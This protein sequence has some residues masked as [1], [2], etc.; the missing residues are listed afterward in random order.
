MYGSHPTI[1]VTGG[2]GY[3]GSHIAQL[4]ASL[5]YHVIIIDDLSQQGNIAALTAMHHI[6]FFQADFADTKLLDLLFTTYTITA[7][8]HCA[9]FIEVGESVRNPLRYYN[10]NVAKTITLLEHM[11]KHG[12]NNFIFS[13]S[14]AVYGVP[15]QLPLKEEHPR[16]PISPYGHTK[17]MVEQILAAMAT[18]YDFKYVAL[19]YF[20]AAGA[21]TEYNLGE[22]HTPETHL[23]P[24]VIEAALHDK[25]FTLFG[26]HHPTPDGTCV[27]DFVHVRDI[28]HAHANALFYLQAGGKSDLFNL[29]TGVGFSVTQIINA[30]EKITDKKINVVSAPARAGDPPI[31]IACS[32]KALQSLAWQAHYS[33]LEYII[34]TAVEFKLLKKASVTGHINLNVIKERN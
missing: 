27:R 5:N 19:R 22:L 23:I 8:I 1:I 32:H 9:A 13:S 28:A 14:C 24:L 29:G 16:S 21:N 7:V 20:N 17:L 18:A 26:T 30:V 6:T 15:Q 33:V 34:Q 2:A 4:L 10:N 12:T 11:R 3:I 31:L 25:P